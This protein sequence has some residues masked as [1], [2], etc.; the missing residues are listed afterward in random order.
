M[1]LGT[2]NIKLKKKYLYGVCVCSLRYPACRA[3]AP[4]YTVI[5]GLS[6]PAILFH[7]ISLITRFS[8]KCMKSDFNLN[9]I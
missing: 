7:I 8:G 4:Y 3:L 5:C 2:T 6:G 9:N 1:M